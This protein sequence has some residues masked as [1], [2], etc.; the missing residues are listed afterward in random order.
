[1]PFI[2]IAHLYRILQGM[3]LSYQ[4]KANSSRQSV[5]VSFDPPLAGYEEVKPRLL[6]MKADADEAL[7]TV[8][9]FVAGTSVLPHPAFRRKHLRSPRSASLSGRSR[10]SL[11]SVF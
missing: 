6:S 7:G 9:I 5:H 2:L 3:K 8:G 11:L 1:M 10:R 4:T